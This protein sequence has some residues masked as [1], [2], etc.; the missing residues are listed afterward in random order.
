MP[1]QWRVFLRQSNRYSH[2]TSP[3]LNLPLFPLERKDPVFPALFFEG[4]RGP[5][6][7]LILPRLEKKPK[8]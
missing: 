2:L 3:R 6:D 4:Q 7:D 8:E 1:L 5:Y